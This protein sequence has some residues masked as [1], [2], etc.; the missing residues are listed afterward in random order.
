MS[1]GAGSCNS[2]NDPWNEQFWTQAPAEHVEPKGTQ[3]W[4]HELVD[5]TSTTGWL[6][7]RSLVVFSYGA[8]MEEKG[9]G[10]LLVLDPESPERTTGWWAKPNCPFETSSEC[11]G[12]NKPSSWTNKYFK[13]GVESASLFKREPAKVEARGGLAD[14]FGAMHQSDLG[15]HGLVLSK[16]GQYFVMGVTEGGQACIVERIWVCATSWLGAPT[17]FNVYGRGADGSQCELSPAKLS[18]NALLDVMRYVDKQGKLAEDL[19]KYVAHALVKQLARDIA[20]AAPALAPSVAGVGRAKKAPPPATE[21][22]P[23]AVEVDGKDAASGAVEDV[24]EPEAE[25]Q[26]ELEAGPEPVSSEAA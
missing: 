19:E 13:L 9:Q 20:T 18:T 12:G 8:K 26:P 22:E 17:K 14:V 10:M 25:P 1:A 4:A 11:P 21:A 16:D 24:A 15:I 5:P 6:Q 7:G 3:G 23:A 2:E